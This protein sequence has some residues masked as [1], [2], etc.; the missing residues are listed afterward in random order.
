MAGEER[1]SH[2]K[3]EN[4]GARRRRWWP[5]L[6]VMAFGCDSQHYAGETGL[7]AFAL[8]EDTP[9]LVET[10]EESFFQVEHPVTFAFE[11]P[12]S[13]ELQALRRRDAAPFSRAPWLERHDY[14]IEIDWV[15]INLDDSPRDVTLT[16]NG[17]N[18]FHEYTPGFQVD[19]E[20]VIPDFS[21]WERRIALGP[22]ERRSGTL[23]EEQCD[24]IA[25]DLAS[26]VNGAPN[27]NQIVHPLSASATDARSQAFIPAVVPALTGIRAGL[28]STSAGNVLVEFS[29]RLRD[30]RGIVVA[31]EDIDDA[32][33]LPEPE[34]FAPIA[35]EE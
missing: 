10:D 18:E 23:R 9:P 16:F 22:Q 26:V 4:P 2:E 28:Q 27:S 6:V 5:L 19:D 8:T 34:A 1:L 24:E 30:D 11:A 7:E 14:E 31:A 29:V 20:E 35:P 25:V 3:P 15:L 17:I 21:Q 32:W 13:E 12:T 33:R